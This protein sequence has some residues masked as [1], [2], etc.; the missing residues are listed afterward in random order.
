MDKEG[1]ARD[2][3]LVERGGNEEVYKLYVMDIA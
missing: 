2:Q 3:R 1:L